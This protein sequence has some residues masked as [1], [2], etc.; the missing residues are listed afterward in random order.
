MELSKGHANGGGRG[1]GVAV[2]DEGLLQEQALT[3]WESM[4]DTCTVT[5][6]NTP[7]H[8]H[9]HACTYMYTE[10]QETSLRPVISVKYMYEADV[11]VHVYSITRCVVSKPQLTIVNTSPCKQTQDTG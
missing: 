7:I 5:Q 1:G 11:H 9:A 2:G 4:T 8:V 6:H 3:W 10:F